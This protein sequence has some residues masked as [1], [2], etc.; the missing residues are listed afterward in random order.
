[1]KNCKK[2]LEEQASEQARLIG[3]GQHTKE[4]ADRIR[5]RRGGSMVDVD[6]IQAVSRA[7]LDMTDEYTNRDDGLGSA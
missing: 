2:L 6:E 7:E 1:M 4:L 3:W 5:E